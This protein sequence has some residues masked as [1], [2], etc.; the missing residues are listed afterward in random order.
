[1]TITKTKSSL[2]FLK[3][4]SHGCVAASEEN[5]IQPYKVRI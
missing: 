2:L 5:E 3:S 4:D 1:M